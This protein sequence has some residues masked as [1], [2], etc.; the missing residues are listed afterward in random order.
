MHRLQAPPTFTVHKLTRGSGVVACYR[1]ADS[2]GSGMAQTL[3]AEELLP[4]WLAGRIP[5][6]PV[7]VHRRAQHERQRV[8]STSLHTAAHLELCIKPSQV[9]NQHRC[10]HDLAQEAVTK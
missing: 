10:R 4:P 5:E 8:R 7:L 1:A 6:G 2:Y 9:L 3:R